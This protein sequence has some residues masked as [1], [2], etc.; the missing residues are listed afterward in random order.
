MG[1]SIM[2]L[3]TFIAERARCHTYIH[4]TAPRPRRPP[5]AQ[6]PI[7]PEKKCVPIWDQCRSRTRVRRHIRYKNNI[8]KVRYGIVVLLF[9][10]TTTYLLS[11]L[12]SYAY[13]KNSH[14]VLANRV[15]MWG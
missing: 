6:M 14:V 2:I 8:M 1:D 4:I 10:L 11:T 13:Y 3:L 5:P 12:A 9:I 7:Q 15:G